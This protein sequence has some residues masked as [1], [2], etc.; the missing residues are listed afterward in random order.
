MMKGTW[1]YFA[2]EQLAIEEENIF[3]FDLGLLQNMPVVERWRQNGL[4]ISN[5]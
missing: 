1:R 3:R 5:V 2:S 4:L